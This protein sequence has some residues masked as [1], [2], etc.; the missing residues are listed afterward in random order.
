NR[1]IIFS[2]SFVNPN[3]LT[4]GTGSATAVT[5]QIG[6]TTT[7]TGGGTYDV[8]PQFNLGSGGQNISYL[9]TAGPQNI[10]TE[11]NPARALQ[12]LT[13]DDN[14][15]GNTLTL[16]GGD[17]SVNQLNLT[18][19]IVYTNSSNVLRAN[20]ITGGS[21]TAHINGPLQ[22]NIPASASGNYV[23]PVGKS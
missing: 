16:T 11:V 19:G 15:P 20:N 9:R 18:N 21:A 13:V 7:P 1:I 6:N 22:R 23:W 2:G 14:L 17:L 8:S 12:T 4:L 3:K 5:I 10:G